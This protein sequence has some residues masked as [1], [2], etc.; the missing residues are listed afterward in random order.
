[1]AKSRRP[2]PPAFREQMVELVR[3]GRTPA[4]LAREFEPTRQA[5][6]QWVAQAE[7]NAGNR[8]DGA[9]SAEGEELR[10][11]RRENLRLREQRDILA[12]AAAWFARETGPG[13]Y[14]FMSANQVR[15]RVTAMARVFG[16]SP[17]GYYAWRRRP[18]SA[19]ARVDADLTARV[20]AIHAGSRG[21][22]GAPRIRVELAAA[23]IA[24]SRKRV[25]RLLRAAGL[26]GVSRR[27]WPGTTPREAQA[28]PAPDRVNRRFQAATPN[29]LWVADS[30]Y[31]PTLAGFLY[32]AI[33]LDVFSRRV[34]G[35]AMAAHRGTALVTEALEMAVRQRR[36]A[37]VLHH[38]DQGC[39]YTSLAFGARCRQW[40]VAP[41]MGSVGDCYDNAMAESFFATLECELLDRTS[42]ATQAAARAAVFDFIEGWYNTR[43]RHSGLGYLSPLA[44]ERRQQADP[45]DGARP[46]DDL[47]APTSPF[48]RGLH[49]DHRERCTWREV[50]WGKR[51]PVHET[52]ATSAR[53][54]RRT[55][56]LPIRRS[57]R[58]RRSPS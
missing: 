8:T 21:T 57:A 40:G 50:N 49:T 16:V 45:V 39:Q 26:A 52:G 5:I 42:L 19:R 7:R 31:V 46:V 23:G 55:W 41:S 29:R 30:T 17:S 37:G 2:Y 36:P 15:F 33:V 1:M 53:G 13:V 48:A 18:R 54:S 25:A 20:R 27:R 38:S 9:G 3:S 32:L 56:W 11:L 34:V 51:L 24:V 10:R 28:R 47:R 58:S 12:T 6:G 44:F 14:R 43:R 22:Y 4:A 35:W